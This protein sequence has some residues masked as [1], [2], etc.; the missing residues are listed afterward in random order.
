MTFDLA[1]FRLAGELLAHSSARQALISENVANADTPGYRARDLAP[2]SET[3]ASA[4]LR[5]S[6]LEPA[7]TRPGHGGVGRR[8]A[9]LEASFDSRTGADSP[10]RNDVALE[11]QMVRAAEVRMQH[12]LA[13]NVY[14]KSMDILRLG[15]GRGR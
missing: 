9:A 4:G 5:D 3:Y 12:D 10:N 14:R 1:I 2:F 6:G 11:D 15:L 7:Q 13:L 8:P